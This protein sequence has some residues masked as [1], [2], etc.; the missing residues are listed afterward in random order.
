MKFGIGE[1]GGVFGQGEEG[2]LAELK[3]LSFGEG[4]ERG[5]TGV[6]GISAVAEDFEEGE[7]GCLVRSCGGESLNLR[8]E[9]KFGEYVGSWCGRRASDEVDGST[10]RCRRFCKG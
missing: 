4:G 2:E 8:G 1:V 6:I 9:E 5:I 10:G 7:V 3:G